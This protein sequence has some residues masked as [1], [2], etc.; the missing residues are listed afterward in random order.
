M[1]EGFAGSR[2]ASFHRDFGRN[3]TLAWWS[4]PRLVRRRLARIPDSRQVIAMG[5]ATLLPYQPDTMTTAQLAAVSFL[6]RYGGSTHV[7]Y[8]A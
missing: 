8:T 4:L 3:R 1:G 7:A 5:A 2:G 6:A